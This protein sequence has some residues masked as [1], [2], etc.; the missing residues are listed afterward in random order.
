MGHRC[1]DD[2]WL[3]AAL[4]VAAANADSQRCSCSCD[5]YTYSKPWESDADIAARAER[6]RSEALARRRHRLGILAYILVLVS[7]F[8]WAIYGQPSHPHPATLNLQQI[9]AST[10]SEWKDT[11]PSLPAQ[12]VTAVDTESTAEPPTMPAPLSTE[13][14]PLPATGVVDE[15]ALLTVAVP[16]LDPVA[17]DTAVFDIGSSRADV[18]AAQGRPPTYA[19]HHDRT[20]WWGSSRVEFDRDGKVRWVDGTPALNVYRR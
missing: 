16:T 4:W 8:A 1:R 7:Q 18:I 12:I 6:A 2:F 19:A 5:S 15:S 9:P 17:L 3:W 13:A 20:L 14:P 11:E 10:D